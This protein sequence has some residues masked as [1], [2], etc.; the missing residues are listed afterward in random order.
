MI[1]YGK[2]T[3]RLPRQRRH[4]L[5]ARLTVKLLQQHPS[6]L[7]KVERVNVQAL[8]SSLF[9]RKDGL[10][11]TSDKLGTDSSNFFVITLNGIKSVVEVLWNDNVLS[12]NPG[13]ELLPRLNRHDTGEDWNGDT[14]RANVTNPL[15]EDGVIVEHLSEDEFGA[16]IDLGSEPIHFLLLG[17][18]TFRCLRVTLRETS[19]CNTEI[20]RVVFVNVLDEIDGVVETTGSWLP[21]R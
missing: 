4:A 19:D 2:E 1:L 20:S 3:Y 6:T 14:C 5:P 8:D 7:L 17:V 12:L 10:A 9:I 11:H 18:I 15:E 16:C 21:F 13:H